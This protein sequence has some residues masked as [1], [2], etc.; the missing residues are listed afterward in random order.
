[1]RSQVRHVL[2]RLLAALFSE[3][4]CWAAAP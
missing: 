4:S 1:L 3:T 2:E